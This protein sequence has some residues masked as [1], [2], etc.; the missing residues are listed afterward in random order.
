MGEYTLVPERF[1]AEQV[2]PV[3]TECATVG[4]VGRGVGLIGAPEWPTCP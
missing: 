4:N 2:Y 3:P 1:R